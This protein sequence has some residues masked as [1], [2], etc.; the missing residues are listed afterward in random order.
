MEII[1]SNIET[2]IEDLPVLS[3]EDSENFQKVIVSPQFNEIFN[4]YKE[5]YLPD[6]LKTKPEIYQ[7]ISLYLT[8]TN[9]GDQFTEQT[10]QVLYRR[11]CPDIKTFLTD[12]FYM[13]YNNATLYP[14]WKE[15]LEEIFRENSPIR[16]TIFSGC[17]GSGKSTI[18][19]KAFIYVLYRALCLRYPR[20][21]FNI[22]QDST[23]ANIVIS[24]TLKQVFDTNLLPFVKLM[25]TMPCFQRVLSTRAF[26]NFDLDND[27]CPIPFQVEKS[28]GTVFFPDNIILT[29]GSNQG[30]FTGYNVINSFCDEINEKGVEE[31]IALLNTLDNRFSSRFEGSDFVFQSVVSS[32]RTKNSALGEYIRHL[33]KNDP[34]ILKLSPCLWEIKPDPN[35]IGD[36]TTFPVMVGN[37]SIASKIITDPGELKAIEEDRYEPPAG[38][39]LINVPTNFKS[40]FELQLDQSIQDI[41]GITT[42][43]NNSVFRDTT[44]L[45]DTLLL[46]EINLEVNIN[47]NTDILATLEQYDLFEQTLRGHWQFKRAP[48]AERYCH[49]DLSG[50]GQDGQ[51][52]TGLCICHK[53]YEIN[54]ITGQKDTIYV[55]DM[56]LFI[57][58]KNKVDIQA[59]QQFLI[60]LVADKQVLMNTV[61]FDQW[62]S[63]L[64][65]QNLEKSGCFKEVKQLSVDAKLEPYTN[66]ALLI[67][68]G[69]VKVGPCAKLRR[70][71]EALIFD[72]NKVTRTVELKDGCLSGNTKIPLLSGKTVT[73]AELINC[74]EN[75]YVLGY[76]ISMN[77][78]T[79]IKIKNVI[80]KGIHDQLYKITLDNGKEL[81]CTNDHLILKRD[82]TYVRAD[83]LKIGDSLLP[84]TI[85]NKQF[86]TKKY[87]S[88]YNYK[89]IFDPDTHKQKW[90]HRI[91]ADFNTS[92]KEK[93]EL[94]RSNDNSKYLVIHHI[95]HNKFNNNPSNLQ[96]LTLKEHRKLHGDIFT[97][98]NKSEKHRKRTSELCKAG[99]CGW[100]KLNLEKPEQMK[101]I[102]AENGRKSFTKY[103]KSKEKFEKLAKKRKENPE[104][105]T[106]YKEKI[107]KS[108]RNQS[109]ETIQ[110]RIDSWKSNKLNIK[111]AKNTCINNNINP[112]IKHN[113]KIGKCKKQYE[114]VLKNSKLFLDNENVTLEMYIAT[115][116]DLKLKGIINKHS[117]CSYNYEDLIEAGVPLTNHSVIKIEKLNTSEKV[118]D[119]QLD[120]VHNFMI[121][122]GIFVHN[123][124]ALVGAI[125]NAQFNYFDIPQYEYKTKESIDVPFTYESLIDSNKEELFD[126]I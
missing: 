82:K 1:P 117:T 86:G 75:E 101:K 48:N 38:C 91:I 40:K 83:N 50:S 63:L 15:K 68:S 28:T 74:Y 27:K 116:K 8:L 114:L 118:Y 123:C 2:L 64:I 115:I 113:Q 111:K 43:D 100:Q 14:Y 109:K 108:F 62:Q 22:D 103:N 98:Y 58:A 36:G 51:C 18:A 39:E 70:E 32:A 35:F 49:V 16:K 21:V 97:A 84:I 122:S 73:I 85:F 37:G 121:E 112:I 3:F 92:D 34:S 42:D 110:K 20:A 46:P 61:S 77:K 79:P 69:K 11:T 23:I 12:K 102:Y 31:A 95:D 72:K 25:E 107:S 71:L 5:N 93:A 88:D 78:L 125:Y 7:R 33:P 105:D 17:I 29:C 104:Y 9:Q 65:T 60:S 13:G 44:R 54:S 87:K 119:I 57:S 55:V 124:D 4:F 52:D 30:H 81:I 19:R 90:L 45:E 56:L 59:I 96:W 26:E 80:D 67:E 89:A 120:S 10:D 24:M 66:A 126:L 41:A 106:W 53:E 99:K 47:E 6:V 76:D 94:R